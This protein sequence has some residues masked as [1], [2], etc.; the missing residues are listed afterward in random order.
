MNTFKL[1]YALAATFLVLGPQ[2]HAQNLSEGT[3]SRYTAGSARLYNLPTGNELSADA[4]CVNNEDEARAHAQYVWGTNGLDGSNTNRPPINIAQCRKVT[5]VTS[6]WGDPLKH[7]FL[8]N[9]YQVNSDGSIYYNSSGRVG[10]LERRTGYAGPVAPAPEPCFYYDYYGVC[11]GPD[12][13]PSGSG[14]SVYTPPAVDTFSPPVVVAAVPIYTPPPRFV[15]LQGCDGGNLVTYY[16]DGTGPDIAYGACSTAGPSPTYPPDPTPPTIPTAQSFPAPGVN[17]GAYYQLG[18]FLPG[19]GDGDSNAVLYQDFVN[20]YAQYYGTDLSTSVQ[21]VNAL[22]TNAGITD[23][24]PPAPIIA[25]QD[26]TSCSYSYNG[27]QQVADPA[28]AAQQQAA[29]AE[30]AWRAEVAQQAEIQR[31]AQIAEAAWY[32]EMAAN[33]AAAQAA[34]DAQAAAQ[35]AADVA[36][37]YAWIADCASRGYVCS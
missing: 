28:V 14:P 37:Y 9:M 16:N 13:G 1:T 29:A 6:V 32:A 22:L 8:G 34:A 5:D 12:S 20:T 7:T 21:S 30:A 25:L 24:G 19:F 27:C 35:Y 10:T 26:P 17:S 11:N 15:T 3:V 23:F 18:F 2:L 31:Q 33:A 4:A 36:A